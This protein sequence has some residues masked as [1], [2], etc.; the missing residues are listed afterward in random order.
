M[1]EYQLT[2][3]PGA[4]R[5]E[6]ARW[7]RNF[8]T[9]GQ[10]FNMK[11]LLMMADE[12][13]AGRILSKDTTWFSEQWV[14]D[15]DPVMLIETEVEDYWETRAREHK[16]LIELLKKALTGDA[17]AALQYCYLVADHNLYTPHCD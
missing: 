5:I 8:N 16:E 14:K 4:N 9:F 17:G 13:I 15:D 6:L 2:A 7:L 12:M 10:I 1:K 3:K 11:D